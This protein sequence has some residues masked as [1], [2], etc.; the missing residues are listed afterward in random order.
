MA[1]PQCS[2][3]QLDAFY[4][5]GTYWNDTVGETAVQTLHERNQSR[6][7]VR[8]TLELLRR[9]KQLRVLDVGA[10]HG[11]TGVWLE[12]LAPGALASF[13]FLEPDDSRSAEILRRPRRFLTSRVASLDRA[14]GGYDLVFLNHVLEHFADPLACVTQ[15][16]ALLAPEGIAYFETPHADYTYKADVFPHTWFFTPPALAGLGQRAGVRQLL[17]ESFGRWPTSSPIDLFSR[18]AYRASATLGHAGLSAY[19]DDRVWRYSAADNGIWLR[20]VIAR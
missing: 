9:K 3:A 11:W 1:L 2:Q 13:E 19:F 16:T 6:H 5:A 12:Q 4:A 7:R 10:G 15:V 18:A 14:S 20:W 8:L 17:L